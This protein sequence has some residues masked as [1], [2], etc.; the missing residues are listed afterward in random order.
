M[1]R[2]SE[3]TAEER[4][5]IQAFLSVGKSCRWI[6]KEIGRSKS[7]IADV[8][9]CLDGEN[10]TRRRGARPKLSR[11]EGRRAVRLAIS[12]QLSAAKIKQELGVQC[13]SQTILNVINGTNYA[14]YKK[15][16]QAPDLSARHRRAR[17]KFVKDR[18]ANN[19]FWRYVLFS[20]E[21]KF[22][23]DGPDC[24]RFYWHDLRRDDQIFSKRVGGGGSVQIWAFFGASGKSELVFLKGRQISSAYTQRLQQYL[25]PHIEKLREMN[26]E[27]PVIFQQDNCSYHDSRETKAWFE[28][29][30]VD[31]MDWPS[32]S[33]DLNPI[34]NVWGKLSRDV[35]AGG[36]QFRTV[37][38]LRAQIKESW[39]RITQEYLNDLIESM[40]RRLVAVVEATGG[41]TDY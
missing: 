12:Q 33:P 11:R 37:D 30:G 26:P 4:A 40:P 14:R 39:S 38:E 13:H 8:R 28:S 24:Y 31:V 22:N 41:S 23:L 2:G 9:K 10:K 20:D 17:L 21:K 6:A 19:A 16:K 1:P 3:I 35:Y 7:A 5:A 29:A 25:L 15:R 27:N 18:I 34:E 36:R 32:K